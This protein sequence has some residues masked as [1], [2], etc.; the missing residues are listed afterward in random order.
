M[1]FYFIKAK[2]QLTPK[3][4]GDMAKQFETDLE[5]AS[6]AAKLL[7]H[8]ARL[9]IMQILSQQTA[10]VPGDLLSDIPL[11]RG[12]IN[13]HLAALKDAGW[14][15]TRLKGS[16][17][18][19]CVNQEKMSQDLGFL[20]SLIGNIELTETPCCDDNKTSDIKE[21][22]IE[23]SILFLCTGN[24][25]RSQMAEAFFNKYT[26][27]TKYR[28]VSAG[29]APSQDIHPLAIK[30][31]TDINITLRNQR[32][33]HTQEFRGHKTLSMVI[34]VCDEAEKNCPYLFPLVSRHIKMP[35][36]DPAAF[37]GT[38]KLTLEKFQ[39]VRDEIETKIKNLIH[40]LHA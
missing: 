27:G 23:E 19:H 29:T 12:T 15:K 4:C 33:K 17:V 3:E 26:Q 39:S 11:S 1:Y 28:A 5:Q 8:P 10:C 24:S 38:K 18:Q 25:C 31:M 14:V 9:R 40:E 37:K 7:A 21:T 36:E 30:V 20:T 16:Q 35:F 2:T 22:D 6:A 32:P 34:F 13:Q